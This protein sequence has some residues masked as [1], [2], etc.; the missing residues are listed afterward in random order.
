MSK[1]N[2]PSDL[3]ENSTAP[4]APIEEITG[5]E[6]EK[7]FQLSMPEVN[8][9]AVAAHETREGEE[10]KAAEVIQATAP[11]FDSAIHAVDAAGNPIKNKDGTYQKKRG[12]KAGVSQSATGS[13]IKSVFVPPSQAQTS[14][15][16]LGAPAVDNQGQRQLA[17]IT[18]KSL[19]GVLVAAL[20]DEMEPS[21]EEF[22]MTVDAW[23]RLYREKNVQDLPPWAALTVIY[24]SRVIARSH[25]PAVKQRL[26]MGAALI[27]KLTGARKNSVWE[28]LSNWFR[29][30]KSEDR[31]S[32]DN[33]KGAE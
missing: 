14:S 27:G 5:A 3:P 2:T 15:A 7:D 24:T 17:I 33:E 10:K 18:A 9:Q 29:G 1:E 13:N 11:G 28:R 21:K 16:T 26:G 6:L 19:D 32:S 4:A 8:E 22:D 23:E 30:V 20:S 31:S 12:R 25:K